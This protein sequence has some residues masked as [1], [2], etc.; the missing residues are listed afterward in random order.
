VNRDGKEKKERTSK[1]ER[2]EEKLA[3]A[4]SSLSLKVE[5]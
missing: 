4:I 5:A 1:T 3:H 2:E